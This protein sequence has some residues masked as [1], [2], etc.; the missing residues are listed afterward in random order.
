IGLAA[1]QQAN[2]AI[3]H[4][5]AMSGDCLLAQD[6]PVVESFDDALAM[7]ALTLRRIGR[8]LRDMH[9]ETCI[10]LRRHASAAGQSLIAQSE[11]RV[12]AEE[13]AQHAVSGLFAG[14]KEGTVFFDTL[15]R[16][17]G[18]LAIRDLVA[19]ATAQS[20]QARSVSDAEQAT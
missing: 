8:R 11:G 1:M 2:L 6:A 10:E 3:V 7:L 20:G 14:L 4:M 18:A 5:N 12:Q 17:P 13:S 15:L 16:D 9:M 19:E